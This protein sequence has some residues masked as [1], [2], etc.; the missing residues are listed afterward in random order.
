MV[1][2][3][4]S[5]SRSG[6]RR[7]PRSQPV[8]SE[9][10]G[11]QQGLLAVGN[12]AAAFVLTS[13]AQRQ[14]LDLQQH[15][16]PRQQGLEQRRTPCSSVSVVTGGGDDWRTQ[17]AAWQK[18]GGYD[19]A[20]EVSRLATLDA[21][22]GAESSA[23]RVAAS[24]PQVSDSP[25]EAARAVLYHNSA[26]ACLN[27]SRLECGD[28][29]AEK[30]TSKRKKDNTFDEENDGSGRS[31]THWISESDISGWSMPPP[32]DPKKVR[33]TFFGR[34]KRD[35]ADIVSFSVSGCVRFQ[36]ERSLSEV[37]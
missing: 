37:G 33:G 18:V 8:Y 34:H 7:S 21:V 1:Q 19:P 17:K 35:S 12:L 2:T 13:S 20:P 28:E 16:R 15:K 10:F 25:S 4:G 14:E 36:F 32:E 31:Q 24:C 11:M 26:R 5:L 3:N 23:N 6:R 29:L 22:P 30:M 9:T 27:P